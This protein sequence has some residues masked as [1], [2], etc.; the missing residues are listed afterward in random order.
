MPRTYLS[1]YKHVRTYFL[2]FNK[3]QQVLFGCFRLPL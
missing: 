2:E 1:Y 3:S